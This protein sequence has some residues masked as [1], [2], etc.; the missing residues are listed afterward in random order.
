[1][2]VGRF[3]QTLT[4]FDVIPLCSWWRRFRGIE[5]PKTVGV[6]GVG[7]ILIVGKGHDLDKRIIEEVVNKG[8]RVRWIHPQMEGTGSAIPL[9]DSVVIA[10]TS[11]Q[12]ETL[13]LDINN[14][15]NLTPDLLTD[16]E[17][18]IY[19]SHP[20]LDSGITNLINLADRQLQDR[21]EKLIF[22]FT[23]PSVEISSIWGAIDDVVMGGV[24]D[25]NIRMV[26]GAARF[27]G[28]VSTANSGGF[29]SVR[30]RNLEP[31]LDLSNYQ[32]IELKVKGD[33]QR[34]KLF[35][36]T[37]AGWDSL[38]YSYSFDTAYN[39]WLNVQIP[40]DRM[41][42]VFRAKTV[43]SAP[44]INLSEICAFQIMLSKFEYDGQLNPQFQPG[45]FSLEIA[46]LKAY[47]GNKLTQFVLVENGENFSVKQALKN[48]NLA[49]K[50]VQSYESDR[51]CS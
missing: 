13:V 43:P 26:D 19:L 38:A 42:A 23:Q 18:I 5:Q 30:T 6:E 41:V 51:I 44:S 21:T 14:S 25:S 50:F 20:D 22:D 46:S 48:T 37:N 34:Y 24:S 32:G 47:G 35:V 8:C 39:S 4:Y 7:V 36:R 1:M 12:V 15:A 17:S 10:N 28:N 27:S 31:R 3:V 45:N 2:N 29:A 16:V 40:F 9:A 49:Y 33:G 11:P